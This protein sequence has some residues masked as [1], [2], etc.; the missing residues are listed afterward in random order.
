MLLRAFGYS[1]DES[2]L[3][4]FFETEKLPIGQIQPD[5]IVMEKVVD[6]ET[7][8]VITEPSHDLTEDTIERLKGMKVLELEIL[9]YDRIKDSNVLENTLKRDP[10][11]NEEEGSSAYLFPSAS[12]RSAK[13]GNSP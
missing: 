8:E 12:G 1:D 2:I 6:Q 10:T 11:K 13:H 9:K 7:G 4:L 5:M 3:R